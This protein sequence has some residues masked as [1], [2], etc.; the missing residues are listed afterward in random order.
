[1]KDLRSFHHFLDITFER[2]PDGLFLHQRTYT[3]DVI[4]R[5]HHL[6]ASSRWHIPS[7]THLY[8]GCHQACG[9]DNLQTVHESSQPQ[10]EVCFRLWSSCQG[11]FLVPEHHQWSIV[12]D[13]HWLEHRL[14]HATDMSA[15]ARPSGA[16]SNGH[17]A[18]PT[19][20]LGEA[21]L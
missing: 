15:Q 12:P 19:L 6:W 21:K 16:S 13:V 17:E 20:S 10:D 18:H 5:Q 9:H 8:I 2:C 11:W 1:M 14:W 7:S 4:K 3:L